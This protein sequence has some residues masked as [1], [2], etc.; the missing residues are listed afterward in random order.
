MICSISFP[1]RA[2]ILL[3]VLLGL[4]SESTAGQTRLTENTMRL[5]ETSRPAGASIDD[6]A[7]LAG[8]WRGEGLGASAEEIWLPP[9]GKRM[10]AVFRLSREGSVE[11]Y[12]IVT[13]VEEEGTL[14][15][16]LKHFGPDLVGW[17]EKDQTVDFRLV[18]MDPA[19]AWFDG[20][21]VRRLHQD[22]MHIWVA[23]DRGGESPQ[24]AH[25]RYRRVRERP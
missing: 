13:L 8:H 22:E 23:L 12:E 6:V 25:F 4:A 7:W 3:P 2:L 19:T 14:V 16:R 9:L 18:R 15:L 20:F 5:D 21:T 11:F 24:E 17:E 10:S 1:G